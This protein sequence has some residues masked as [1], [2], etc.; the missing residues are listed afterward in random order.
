MPSHCGPLYGAQRHGV[1]EE[2]RCIPAAP[3]RE[4]PHRD[5]RNRSMHRIASRRVARHTRQPCTDHCPAL[6][7]LLKSRTGRVHGLVPSIPRHALDTSQSVSERPGN[8]LRSCRAAALL[9]IGARLGRPLVFDR[10]PSNDRHRLGRALN[11]IEGEY[12]GPAGSS[13]NFDRRLVEVSR[14]NQ[15]VAQVWER[16]SRLKGAGV[17]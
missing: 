5:A 15:L 4:A 8:S 16:I 3:C 1:H 9:S 12:R 2:S 13:P 6:P 17:G 10:C 14:L 11:W 7:L